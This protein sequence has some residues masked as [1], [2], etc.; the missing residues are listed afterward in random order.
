MQAWRDSCITTFL[1]SGPASALA[2]YAD[3]LLG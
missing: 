1:V 3:T 2:G